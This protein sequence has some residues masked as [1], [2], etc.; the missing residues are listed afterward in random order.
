MTFTSFTR[1]GFFIRCLGCPGCALAFAFVAEGR[2]PFIEASKLLLKINFTLL[3]LH[4]CTSY[5]FNLF[6]ILSCLFAPSSF[7]MALGR[8]P[9]ARATERRHKVNFLPVFFGHEI[10][11]C[12]M[13]GIWFWTKPRTAVFKFSV[14]RS[15]AEFCVAGAEP[16]LF[17]GVTWV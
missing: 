16:F 2:F 4:S 10:V 1:F 14:K 9:V 12:M 7:C 3:L 6:N 8:I 17:L 13:S 5:C 11:P 15:Y